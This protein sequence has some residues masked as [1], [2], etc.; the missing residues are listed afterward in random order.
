MQKCVTL[1]AQLVILDKI[2]MIYLNMGQMG[3]YEFRYLST[4][5]NVLGCILLVCYKGYLN[6]TNT[7]EKASGVLFSVKKLNMPVL[8]GKPL[9]RP[10]WSLS[11][12][13]Q[14]MCRHIIIAQSSIVQ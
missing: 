8:S 12:W 9:L 5:L 1:S 4:F 11:Q 10:I 6:T 14:E 3:K 13:P 7:V 2:H